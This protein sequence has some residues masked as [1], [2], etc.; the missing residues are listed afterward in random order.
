MFN[1]TERNYHCG[2]SKNYYHQV[3]AP[4]WN[5]KCFA[6]TQTSLTKIMI[7]NDLKRLFTAIYNEMPL[8]DIL[9]VTYR[10]SHGPC[11]MFILLYRLTLTLNQLYRS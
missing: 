9:Y 7:K 8:R 6:Q 4:Y 5:I 11:D 1:S 3:Q 10:L 2:N